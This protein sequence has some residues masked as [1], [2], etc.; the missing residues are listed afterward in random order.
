MVCQ[1]VVLVDETGWAVVSGD[2]VEV[3]LIGPVVDGVDDK[4]VDDWDVDDDVGDDGGVDDVVDGVVVVLV[5]LVVE[6][7]VDCVVVEVVTGTVSGKKTIHSDCWELRQRF[8]LY[9]SS[10]H[11]GK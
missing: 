1:G 2:L 6:G 5:V 3:V 7:V 10:H 11:I 9:V 8:V 4:A